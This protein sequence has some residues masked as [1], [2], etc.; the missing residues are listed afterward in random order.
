MLNNV[1]RT[2]L[3]DHPFCGM[4]K[5]FDNHYAIDS[6]QSSDTSKIIDYINSEGT[7]HYCETSQSIGSSQSAS[8]HYV[9]DPTGW[10]IQL[11]ISFSSAPKDCSSSMTQQKQRLNG[12]GL[13]AGHVNPACTID[14]SKCPS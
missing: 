11:D 9:F 5:W 12:R 4:D 7:L 14:L 13:L 2:I 6:R 1:H 8:V 3:G 10:G